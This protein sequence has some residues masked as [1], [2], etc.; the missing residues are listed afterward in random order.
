MLKLYH[1]QG[2]LCNGKSN[3]E[4]DDVNVKRLEKFWNVNID[5]APHVTNVRPVSSWTGIFS[6][7]FGEFWIPFKQI[8]SN[9]QSVS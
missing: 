5:K 6:H 1:G 2:I 4:W 3:L 8:S 7:W 9:H